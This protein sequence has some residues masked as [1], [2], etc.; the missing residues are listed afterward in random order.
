MF[1]QK[2]EEYR[3]KDY[4]FLN[5]RKCQKNKS[6]FFQINMNIFFPKLFFHKIF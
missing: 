4:K 6:P 1:C 3:L 5:L 2:G